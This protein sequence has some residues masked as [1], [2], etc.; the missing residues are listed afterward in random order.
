MG[1]KDGTGT[2]WGEKEGCNL[3]VFHVDGLCPLGGMATPQVWNGTQDPQVSPCY[4]WQQITAQPIG[5]VSFPSRTAIH[6][7]QP[8]AIA[9]VAGVAQATLI[10]TFLNFE[11]LDFA[12]F[13]FSLMS[14]CVQLCFININT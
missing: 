9:Q 6:I 1:E 7:A 11:V 14:L 8:S 3:G 5:H 12:T 2:N 10:P 13:M 4:S